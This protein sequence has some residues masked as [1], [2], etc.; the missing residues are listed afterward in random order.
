MVLGMLKTLLVTT[1]LVSAVA[2]PPVW[3]QIT[4][5]G[6]IVI[7]PAQS[8][9]YVI[10]ELVS[11]YRRTPATYAQSLAFL[12]AQRPYLVDRF[13]KLT[14]KGPAPRASNPPTAAGTAPVAA[15]GTA[16]SRTTRPQPA[17][18]A[19]KPTTATVYDGQTAL[20]NNGLFI[21]LGVLG[22]AAAAGGGGGG[23]DG[24]TPGPMPGTPEFFETPEYKRNSGLAQINASTRYAAGGQG[25]NVK[26]AILDSGI[27][28]PNGEFAS[29][30]D[31]A[32]SKSFF[33]GD[34]SLQDKDPVGHGT[35]V[36]GIAAGAKNNLAAQGVAFASQ[37]VIFRGI[38][39]AST[40][41]FYPQSISGAISAGARVMNNSWGPV[42]QQTRTIITI[43]DFASRAG[44]QAFLENSYGPE[45]MGALNTAKTSN[46]LSVFAAGNDSLA[47]VNVMGGIPVWMPE[48]AGSIL[49]VVAVDN[50]NVIAEFSNRCGVAKDM[51]LAA[52][53]V[54]IEATK[55]GG[56]GNDNITALS[57]TSMAAPHVSGAAA[58]LISQWPELDSSTIARLLLDTSTDLGAPGVDEVYGHGLLN[59][60]NAV[61]P[62]GTLMIYDGTSVT[63]PATPLAQS[64]IV[65]SGAM[66]GAL[67]AA[68]SAQEMIVGDHYNRGYAM[69]MD[70]LLV[71]AAE[72]PSASL[73]IETLSAAT[74]LRMAGFGDQGRAYGVVRDDFRTWYGDAEAVATSAGLLDHSTLLEGGTTGQ[75]GVSLGSGWDARM[76]ATFS[77]EGAGTGDAF[78]LGLYGSGPIRASVGVGQMNEQDQV[79]GTAFQGASGRDGRAQTSF[80][81]LGAGA[82]L[83][84]SLDIDV[85]AVFGQ[86]DFSQS[87]LVVGGQNMA[88]SGG[89]LSI[90]RPVPGL[91]GG[92]IAFNVSMPI[93]VTEGT[94]TVDVPVQRAASVNGLASTAVLRS[95][96]DIAFQND[97]QPM[98][99]GMSFTLP[100][101]DSRDFGLQLD[102]GYRIVSGAESQPFVGIAFTRRF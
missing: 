90:S 82:T 81:T 12:Q 33:I 1:L 30:I 59:V 96:E 9:E 102:G 39:A 22:L 15:G 24:S 46:L 94:L 11:L 84:G 76:T 74:G 97:V 99:V 20:Q 5:I 25:Q 13:N 80:V 91:S 69:E 34:S 77:D 67:T 73:R 78:S 101:D 51:C 17:G 38:G 40:Y 71:S 14:L 95:R 70:S 35:H 44:L 50:S 68:L 56:S 85:Q 58:L 54:E 75:F 48:F 23:D 72:G 7:T 42:D 92:R 19:E 66:D 87:G 98:D 41:G 31:L 49:A 45:I 10:Q 86:T 21:A 52:P 3:G 93:V 2:A 4:R 32:N 27:D 89:R 18:T 6:S 53:G 43:T 55:L 29:K 79:L 16:A 100:I 88:S 61:R 26:I 36:A 28:L 8:D 83:G 63:G 47:E 64:A 37:L 62:A 65:T 57:G 60:A